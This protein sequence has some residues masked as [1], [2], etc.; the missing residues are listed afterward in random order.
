VH[1]LIIETDLE[2]IESA[3]RNYNDP[4][5]RQNTLREIEMKKPALI[6]YTDG[7]Y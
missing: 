5:L 4:R 3:K 1:N 7:Y 2:D 6:V